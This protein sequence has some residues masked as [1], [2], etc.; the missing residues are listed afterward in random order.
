MASP[1]GGPYTRQTNPASDQPAAPPPLFPFGN[2]S[3]AL[4]DGGGMPRGT[5]L[6]PPLVGRR[7]LSHRPM[8]EELKRYINALAGPMERYK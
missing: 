8:A 7:Q 1:S 6:M 5:S 2:M 4:H 3:M